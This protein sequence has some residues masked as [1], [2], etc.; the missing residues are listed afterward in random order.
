MRLLLVSRLIMVNLRVFSVGDFISPAFGRILLG[1]AKVDL[2][3]LERPFWYITNGTCPNVEFSLGD[4]DLFFITF[5]FF[6]SFRMNR[7]R[8]QNSIS[9]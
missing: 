3:T 4:E 5:F 7:S 9:E 6:E 2:S 8:G 1:G